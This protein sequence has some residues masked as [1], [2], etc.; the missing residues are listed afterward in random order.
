M[1]PASLDRSPT[2]AAD[3]E[4]ELRQ[5]AER[6][7]LRNYAAH[8]LH[9]LLGQTGFRMLQAPTFLPAYVHALSGSDLWVGAARAAQSLGQC[10][11]PLLGATHVEHRARVLRLGVRVGALMRV[12]VLGIALAGFFL[13]P[14]PALAAT[15]VCLVLFGFFMGMQGVIFN[16]L[17]AKLIPPERRGALSGLRNSL[18]GITVFFVSLL[19]G[20]LI[21]RNAL[22]NGYASTFLLT[23]ALTSA[24]LSTLVLMREP[25][26][27]EVRERASVGARLAEL[28][29][30][31]REDRDFAAYLLARAV[32]SLGR[33]AMPYY[34]LYA[35]QRIAIS[36]TELGLLTAAFG[37]AQSGGDLLWGTVADRR[38]F[39]S[40]LLASLALW[41]A[42]TTALLWV[43]SLPEL[44]AV[45][46]ALAAGQGG[47]LLS[48]QN[49]VLEFGRRA[50]LPMRIAVANSA[51]E[52]VG[53]VGPVVAGLMLAAGMSYPTLFW[54]AIA[55][56]LAALG[57]VIARVREPRGRAA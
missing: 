3:P 1:D 30:L 24:G 34:L 2:P 47:F 28:P 16:V 45:F 33:A 4:A 12:Q 22:G 26:A 10:L 21:E 14:L 23:F 7:L 53:A 50:A 48:S 43:G 52:L 42:A 17:M 15:C 6:H 40:I 25:D 51:A 57:L 44:V 49:L 37:V 56:K 35:G 54:I 55:V 11:T 8:L 31:L 29:Q 36:G 39:R 20:F 27:P 18:S 38:G 5:F 13:A 19:G 46:A 9:G 32:A 41:A